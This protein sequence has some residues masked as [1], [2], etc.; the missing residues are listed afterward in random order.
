MRIASTT[1]LSRYLDAKS[2][3][4]DARK[5]AVAVRR[6]LDEAQ[7]RVDRELLDAGN[8]RSA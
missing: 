8:A 1:G 6:L 2:K 4:L 3:L 7:E 5:S